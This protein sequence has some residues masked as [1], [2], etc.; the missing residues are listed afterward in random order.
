MTEIC[1]LLT[2]VMWQLTHA[3]LPLLLVVSTRPA[4]HLQASV[5]IFKVLYHVWL[6][7]MNG[8]AETIPMNGLSFVQPTLAGPFAFWYQ[9]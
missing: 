7:L 9:I 5:L 3:S 8:M 2:P 6:S 1:A 4:M